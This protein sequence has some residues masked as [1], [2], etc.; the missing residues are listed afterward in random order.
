MSVYHIRDK[1]TECWLAETEG[2]FL[3]HEG[4][5]DNQRG[6]D[7]L[8]LIG[9]QLLIQSKRSY[10]RIFEFFQVKLL[11]CSHYK[12]HFKSYFCWQQLLIELNFIRVG[13]CRLSFVEALAKRSSL[14]NVALNV[15][16]MSS[17]CALVK[18]RINFTCIFKV[19]QIFLVATRAIF[20]KTLKIRVELILNYPRA[21]VITYTTVITFGL[22]NLMKA[23]CLNAISFYVTFENCP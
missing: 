18:L 21:H 11:F 1:I 2:I 16:N 22:T 6:H 15:I 4:T 12:I 10:K 19:V 17:Q 8:I 13:A 7:S 23:N 14:N 3:N 5:F 9:Q 20:V